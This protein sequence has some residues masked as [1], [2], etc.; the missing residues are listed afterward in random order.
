MAFG[1]NGN[2]VL[3]LDE[4]AKATVSLRR[5][6]GATS[7]VE[8]HDEGS[9]GFELR[10][11]FEDERSLSLVDCQGVPSVLPWGFIC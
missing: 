5:C 3:P 6:G 7:P 10:G 8:D 2:E 11:N 9:S 4:R 1:V